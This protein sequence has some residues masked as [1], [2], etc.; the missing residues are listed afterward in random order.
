[1]KTTININ[2]KDVEIELTT[3]QLQ[4]IKKSAINYTDI[5]TFEDACRF[6][7]VDIQEFND[8]IEDLPNDVKAYMKLRIIVK[9]INGGKSMDYKNLLEYK[10]YPW[11]NAVGSVPGFSYYDYVYGDSVS[12]V[13]SRLCFL[14]RDRAKY[15]ANQFTSIYNQY[16]NAN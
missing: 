1:M 10:Y 6:E 11:F 3:D 9:A 8:L 7:G 14:D 13:G 5:K 2:G 16:I 4:K 15:A 12:S